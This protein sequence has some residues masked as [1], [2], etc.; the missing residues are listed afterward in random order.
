MRAFNKVR[1]E[2][3]SPPVGVP[4]EQYCKAHPKLLTGNPADGGTRH[5][6]E[7]A[8]KRSPPQDRVHTNVLHRTVM[9][10]SPGDM[11]AGGALVSWW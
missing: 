7:A 10:G 8:Q 11:G 5:E 4:A 3:F 1:F 2:D 9:I 6:R